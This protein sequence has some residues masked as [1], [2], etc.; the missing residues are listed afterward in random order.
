MRHGPCK[1]GQFDE[2]WSV[3]KGQSDGPFKKGHLDGP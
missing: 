1:K 2:L 3:L